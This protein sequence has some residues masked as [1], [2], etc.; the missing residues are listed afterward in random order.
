MPIPLTA[1]VTCKNERPNIQRCLDSLASIA[2]ELLVADSGSTDGT[3][4]YVRSRG[5]C[6]VVE[7]EYVTAIDFKNWAIPQAVHEWVLVLDADERIT[8]RLA[9]EIRRLLATSPPAEGYMI[10]RT[11]YLMGRPVRHTDWG[12]DA[13]LRLFRRDL[14]RYD[15]P[16]DHG[17]IHL[18]TG[19]VAWLREPMDHYT[20][21]S[22]A[23]YMKKFDRYTR[24]QA[25][26]WY[27]AGKRPS[28]TR[29]LF[30]PPL[31]FL[32]DYLAYGGFLDG[33]AGLQIAWMCAFYSFM[34][35]A[36]L[37][38]LAEGRKRD[39]VEPPLGSEQRMA[40]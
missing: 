31:R 38:E 36:R 8:P 28:Y 30:S 19:K 29:M 2:D 35:Q 21:W 1:L 18:S 23:E 7:R 39:D 4:E 14:G 40:A 17:N 32:R 12:R 5:D 34:K 10:W 24:V 27:A 37:W 33:M 16:S 11:N 15:G 13:V 26:Q 9:G 25:E 6:R 22:W 3:L 20:T